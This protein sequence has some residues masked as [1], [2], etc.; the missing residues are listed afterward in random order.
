MTTQTGKVQNLVRTV[1]RG[2]VL[3]SC[4]AACL[5]EYLVTASLGGLNPRRRVRILGKWSARALRRIGVQWTLAGQPPEQ[6]MIVSNHL[7][8]LDILL[9]SAVSSCAFVAKQEVR[10]MP[11]VGWIATLCGTIYI[12]RSRRVETHAIRPQMEA[13]LAAGQRLVLFPEGTSYDGSKLLPFHSSLFEPAVALQTPV[14]AAFLRYD[15]ADGDAATVVCYWGK[16]TLFPHLLKLLSKESIQAT[17]KF[18]PQA[19]RFTNRKEAARV[20]QEQV[21]HLRE[22]PEQV[23]A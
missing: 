13:A 4:V 23:T 9:F 3:V 1:T 8:Y 19:L 5:A 21:E 20:M 18:S 15:V 2:T 17:L 6:G 22:A 10:A 11:V 16:M 7:S 14:T 12:D